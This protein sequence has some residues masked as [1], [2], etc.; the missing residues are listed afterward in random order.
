MINHDYARQKYIDE[1]PKYEEIAFCVAQDLRIA[2]SGRGLKCS[3]THRAKLVSSFVK[4]SLI[5]Q[6]DPWSAITDKAGVRV[7][8]GHAADL[9]VALELVYEAFGAPVWLADDREIEDAEDQLRYPRLHAQ[10]RAK[11]LPG[12]KSLPDPA[13]CEI[14]IRTEASDLWSRMSHSMLYKPE[15]SLPKNVRRS[16]YRLLALVE[17]YDREVERAV[18]AMREDPD[19]YL[20]SLV[21][22][23]ESTFYTFCTSSYDRHLTQEVAAVILETLCDDDRQTYLTDL[24]G[25]A[26]V[27]RRRLEGVYRD[28]GPNSPA[29]LH[30]TYILAG[31]PESVAIFERLENAPFALAASWGDHMENEDLLN[32]M[33][34][35]WG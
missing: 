33:R 19:H 20:N 11:P 2:A 26:E 22:Q 18:I 8:V 12:G 1:R 10:V 16:L 35:V 32:E 4:K 27:H 6:G 7:V 23:F 21:A 25:F 9:D 17:L 13:E 24:S 30:G 29:A 5:V 31:Q 34:N 3:I 15:A 14:Q 28:Y